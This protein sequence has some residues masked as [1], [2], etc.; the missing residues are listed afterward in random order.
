MFKKYLLLGVFWFT[1]LVAHAQDTTYYVNGSISTITTWWEQGKQQVFLYNLEG[2]ETLSFTRVKSSFSVNISLV[3][4]K[5]G[6]VS[7]LIETIHSG[8]SPCSMVTSYRFNGT[9]EPLLKTIEHGLTALC[10]QERETWFWN[11]KSK[12]WVKQETVS[13]MPVEDF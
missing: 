5:N 11:K 9:N 2:K 10:N 13:C 4:A 3:Y 1:A 7:H 8:G 6:S 12:G